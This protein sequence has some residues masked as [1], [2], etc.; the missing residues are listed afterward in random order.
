MRGA[1]V[2]LV[3]LV[4]LAVA[5]PGCNGDDDEPATSAETTTPASSE[6]ELGLKATLAILEKGGESCD[7]MTAR[8]IYESYGESGKRGLKRCRYYES[9][10][11]DPNEP[12]PDVDARVVKRSSDSALVQFSAAGLGSLY[13]GLVFD[14]HRWLI[15][16]IGESPDPN[17]FDSAVAKWPPVVKSGIS[18]DELEE[19]LSEAIPGA[20]ELDCSEIPNENLGVWECALVVDSPD[21]RVKRG[22]ALVSVAPNGRVSAI[23][24]SP[25]GHF[26][27]CCLEV[28]ET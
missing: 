1:A 16:Q 2:V 4:A 5:L 24:G 3:V 11:E 20:R 12:R 8:Y 9:R 6:P 17:S 15:D 28:S 23:E 14:G 10:D 27:A 18:G 7:L 19:F 21:G 13:F 26:E 25:A 22:T